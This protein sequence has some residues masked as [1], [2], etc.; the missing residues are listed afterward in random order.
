VN[1]ITPIG[2][3]TKKI[4]DQCRFCRIRPPTTGPRIG[5]IIAGIE[6]IPIT[7]P[8]CWGPATCAIIIIATGMIIPPPAPW[9]TRNT[10]NEVS[11]PARPHSAEPAVN[12]T[13]DTMYT[14]LA[15]KRRAAQPVKGITA[16][17]ESR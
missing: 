1:A 5:A 13:S 16:A 10:T 3:F 7:L 14:C 15:P 2:I 11:E 9:S 17:S 12:S 6:T 8:I 4:H